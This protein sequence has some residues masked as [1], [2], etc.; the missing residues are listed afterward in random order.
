MPPPW[1]RLPLDLL[2]R[3][4]LSKSAVT[5]IA[6][7]ID[8]DRGSHQIEISQR[9]LAAEAGA[10]DRTIRNA[11]KEL[12]AAELLTVKHTGRASV[13]DIAQILPPKRRNKKPISC[14]SSSIDMNDV[15][16][17]FEQISGQCTFTGEVIE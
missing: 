3:E 8:R 12:Q 7:L 2:K 11:I 9:E 16:N 14:Q 1:V 4:D 5:V 10:T 15:A 6:I 13:Y 17:L